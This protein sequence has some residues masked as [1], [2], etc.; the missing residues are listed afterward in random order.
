[1]PY[2]GRT[3]DVIMVE[4]N[5]NP[6]KLPTV[7]PSSKRRTANKLISRWF[8]HRP[9]GRLEEELSLFHTMMM[10]NNRLFVCLLC[11]LSVS[12]S[13]GLLLPKGKFF[14][15][16]VVTCRSKGGLDPS[17]R[18]KLSTRA[19]QPQNSRNPAIFLSGG[20]SSASPVD[21]QEDGPSAASSARIL[22]LI[23]AL[24]YGTLNVSLRLV[25]NLPDPPEPSALSAT[26]GW[27]ATAC[28]A[29][30]LLASQK[31]S[32]GSSDDDATDEIGSDSGFWKA[33]AELALWNFGAQGLLNLGLLSVASARAAFLTQLSV[34][35]TPL[36]SLL[37]GQSIAPTVWVACA[38][39]L[40][41]LTLLSGGLAGIL[42][43]G[44]AVG[45]LFILGGALSWSLY[46]FRLSK[47]GG[48]FDEVRLQ[49]GK[50]AILGGLYSIWWLLSTTISGQNLWIGWRNPV[51][52]AFLLYSALGP[53]T[54]ADVLQTQ[55]QKSVSATEANILLSLEPVFTALC[56]FL[57][58][59]ETTSTMENIG[60]GLILAAALLATR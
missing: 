1:M 15:D 50:T 37:A 41:G 4:Q 57:V 52:W 5:H 51:A 47:I 28:F 24:L 60:G 32:S 33:A 21:K 49:A 10:G 38:V 12:A 46:L 55:G 3:D 2:E 53:G 19:S 43:G 18:E 58:L 48:N 36:I 25:Y 44:L 29:P 16:N 23:V 40:A 11:A 13:S 17:N 9:F 22:L 59:G 30:L 54:L 42:G 27:L 56:A 14:H 20:D 35:M 39:A 34:V 7:H 26:R 6:T 31:T 45:D 8:K